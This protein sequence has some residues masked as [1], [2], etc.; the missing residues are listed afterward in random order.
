MERFIR[1]GKP[2]QPALMPRAEGPQLLAALGEQ[3]TVPRHVNVLQ[4]MQG[5]FRDKLPDEDR[6]ELEARPPRSAPW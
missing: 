4:H 5:Y 1:L 3:A 6:R 2:V